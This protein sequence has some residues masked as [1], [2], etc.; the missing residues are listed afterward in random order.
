ME[1]ELLKPRI[2]LLHRIRS[3]RFRDISDLELEDPQLD[4][5]IIDLV[6]ALR[7]PGLVTMG[8]CHGHLDG[9]TVH[10]FPWVSVYGLWNYSE[11]YP[12]IESYNLVEQIPWEV[13]GTALR[14]AAS[15]INEDGIISLRQSAKDL[16]KFLFANYL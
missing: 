2:F 10:P 9:R 15:A 5:C 1:H 4:E 13:C 14:S 12:I 8:S 11:V 3:E 6:R 7:G 16:A